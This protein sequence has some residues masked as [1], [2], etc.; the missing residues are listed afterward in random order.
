MLALLGSTS[1][2]K[3]SMVTTPRTMPPTRVIATTFGSA[4]GGQQAAGDWSL[5][6][7]MSQINHE[8]G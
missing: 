2:L 3:M 7:G 5:W 1:T 6:S 8:A 4:G